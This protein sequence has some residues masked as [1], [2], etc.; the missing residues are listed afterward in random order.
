MPDLRFI[1]FLVLSISILS[2]CG[3]D[4]HDPNNI[5][6]VWELES[7]SGYGPLVIEG[8]IT[9]DVNGNTL[10]LFHDG[11]LIMEA[12]LLYDEIFENQ[13]CFNLD[14]NY[15]MDV[16]SFTFGYSDKMYFSKS[17]DNSS[18]RL[19]DNCFHCYYYNFTK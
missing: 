11:E 16:P 9:M 4:N 6:G 18:V 13:N 12:T 1:L 8:K 10:E 15:K 14:R 2:S 19:V 3:K 7:I 17:V 5:D